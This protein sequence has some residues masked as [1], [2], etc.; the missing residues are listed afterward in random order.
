[1]GNTSSL[2]TWKESLHRK[3]VE[4]VTLREPIRRK[5]APAGDEQQAQPSIQS[6]FDGHGFYYVDFESR[7]V[8]RDTELGAEFTAGSILRRTGL[9][10]QMESLALNRQLDLQPKQRTL[11]ERPDSDPRQKVRLLLDLSQQHDKIVANRL[12]QERKLRH[13]HRHRLSL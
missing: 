12:A 10:K 7:T 4:A 2:G 11:L 9:D 8:A 1:M 5:H 6:A 3:R 13:R